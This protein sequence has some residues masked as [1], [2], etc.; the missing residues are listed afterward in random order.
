[1]KHLYKPIYRPAAFSGLP[2]GWD[3]VEAPADLALRRPDLPVSRHTF[4]VIAYERQLTAEEVKRH[5]L[6]Y[7]GAA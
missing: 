1:M 5:E 6:E 4:G 3:Y 2:K 7:V